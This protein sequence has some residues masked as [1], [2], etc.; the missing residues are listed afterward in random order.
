MADFNLTEVPVLT[1]NLYCTGHPNFF[2]HDLLLLSY[3]LI[4]LPHKQNINSPS[5]MFQKHHVCTSMTFSKSCT[6]L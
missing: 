2:I 3:H 5:I 6:L 1:T 4:I